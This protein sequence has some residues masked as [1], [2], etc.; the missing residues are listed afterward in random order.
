VRGSEPL[1]VGSEEGW[2]GRI[3]EVIVKIRRGPARR[4]G[5]HV[6]VDHVVSGCGTA[7]V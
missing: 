7:L 1:G 5:Q 3:G 6:A 2:I 4:I